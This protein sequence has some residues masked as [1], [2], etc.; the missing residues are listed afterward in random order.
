MLFLEVLDYILLMPVHLS[1]QHHQEHPHRLRF[2]HG[3]SSLSRSLQPPIQ[4]I[5][6]SYCE[7][8]SLVLE[9]HR[10]DLDTFHRLRFLYQFKDGL[11]RTGHFQ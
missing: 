2:H 10:L 8:G 3:S 9:D 1:G 11:F 4:K 5:K 7:R 6:A